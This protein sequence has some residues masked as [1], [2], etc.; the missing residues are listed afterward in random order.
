MNFLNGPL[1]WGSLAAAGISVPI[2]IHL[3]N[4]LRHRQTDWAA[5]EFLRKALLVRSRRIRMEDILLLIV[6]C[7]ALALV[8][9]ALLRPTLS[10]A[11]AK[12]LGGGQ[13]GVLI[14]L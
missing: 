7:A 10:G 5:M 4:K 6:R 14:A 12:L 2:I 1:L 13:S 8:A 3:L 11:S 9:F